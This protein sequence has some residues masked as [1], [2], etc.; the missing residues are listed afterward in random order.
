VDH[1]GTPAL[2][3]KYIRV[4]VPSDAEQI[5]V[6][7]DANEVLLA[8]DVLVMPVQQDSPLVTEP[9]ITKNP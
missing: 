1:S 2:P 4:L 3:V 5:D 9:A 7:F 6:R 8:E